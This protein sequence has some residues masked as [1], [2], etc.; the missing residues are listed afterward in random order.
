M[1]QHSNGRRRWHT[2]KLSRGFGSE[3]G[4]TQVYKDFALSGAQS[5]V[6]ITFDMY[7]LDTWDGEAFKV[8]IDGVEYSSQ[9]LWLDAY[10]NM[11]LGFENE[12]AITQQMT[13][14]TTNLGGQAG[15]EDEIH[16]YSFYD[17]HHV[18]QHRLGFSS[19]L[20][21]AAGNEQWV[22]TI[23]LSLRIDQRFR[24]RKMQPMEQRWGVCRVT[25]WMRARRSAI[26]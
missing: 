8:W 4:T 14:G 26:H 18:D 19:T 5:S 24:S 13:T 10:N 6:T 20:D 1:E 21:E 23:C 17:Q 3:I 25:T 7:E 16:R 22:S 9:N 2:Y 15:F 12:L 11:Y